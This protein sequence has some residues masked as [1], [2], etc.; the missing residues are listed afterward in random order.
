MNED[1]A[2]MLKLALEMGWFAINRTRERFEYCED[3]RN[4]Y[5][6]MIQT[7]ANKVGVNLDEVTYCC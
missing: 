7:V 5:F 1:E 4:T 3:A 6:N 2:R